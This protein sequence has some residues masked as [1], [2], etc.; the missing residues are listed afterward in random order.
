MFTGLTSP[1]HLILLLAIILL[2][3]GAKRLPEMGRGLAQGIREL[4]EGLKAE[5]DPEEQQ[6]PEAVEGREK[7]IATTA[8]EE[9]R[10]QKKEATA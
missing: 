2:L 4:K 8:Q 1:T 6:H 10:P 7:P 5:E 3:F 9:E